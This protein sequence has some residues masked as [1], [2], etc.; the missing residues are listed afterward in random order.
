MKEILEYNGYRGSN[1][2]NSLD[3]V[4]FGKLIGISDLVTYEFETEEGLKKEFKLAI[5]DY[6]QDLKD[7]GKVP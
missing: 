3:K 7:L 5:E 4:Y 6:L 2:Y 1:E